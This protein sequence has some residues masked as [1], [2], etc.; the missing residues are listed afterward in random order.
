MSCKAKQEVFDKIVVR[1]SLE[2]RQMGRPRM[3]YTQP[4]M[5]R[6]YGSFRKR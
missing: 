5:I 2:W 1:K 6:P 4:R 3:N